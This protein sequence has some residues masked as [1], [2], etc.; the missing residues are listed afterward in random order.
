MWMLPVVG[1]SSPAIIDSSVLLPQPEGPTRMRN[2]PASTSM[3]MPLRMFVAP[4]LLRTL[5][6]ESAPISTFHRA[7]GEPAH[8]VFA[9]DDVDEQRRQ[10]GDHRGSHVDVVFLDGARGVRKI[11]Q[12]HSHRLRIAAREHDAVEEVVF[13]G[14]YSK[15]DCGLE[16]SC[17]HL[18]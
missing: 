14:S 17:E 7:G 4:K 10:R 11:V 1:V 5:R 15:P 13:S 16:Q 3:S 9:C 12:A 6:I 8:E 18:E 2:S